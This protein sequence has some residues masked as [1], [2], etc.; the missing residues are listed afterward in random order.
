MASS[1]SRKRGRTLAQIVEVIRKELGSSIVHIEVN[2]DDIEEFVLDSLLTVSQYKPR[3]HTTTVYLNGEAG[4]IVAEEVDFDPSWKVGDKPLE[5]KSRE[6]VICFLNIE[7]LQGSVGEIINPFTHNTGLY[8][9]PTSA[10]A[11]NNLNAV[12]SI[13]GDFI[14]FKILEAGVDLAQAQADSEFDWWE[15]TNDSSRAFF[16][17]AKTTNKA[18]IT[19]GLEWYL[20]DF[21]YELPDVTSEVGTP[22]IKKEQ[23]IKGNVFNHT[24]NLAKAKTMQAIGRIR[25]KLEGG[26]NSTQLDGASILSDGNELEEKVMESLTTNVDYSAAYQG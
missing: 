9:F 19:L 17:N 22:L 23:T 20:G 21:D 26:S 14:N 11:N 7:P 1:K 10:Q 6:D 8:F 25:G 18:N 12:S 3:V 16:A 24:K 13:M 15:N 5:F 2:N 4:E